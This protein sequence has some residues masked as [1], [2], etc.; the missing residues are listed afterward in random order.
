MR[1]FAY[2]FRLVYRTRY[3]FG[4]LPMICRKSEATRND[5]P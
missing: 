2:S 3:A 1:V 4:L 5:I